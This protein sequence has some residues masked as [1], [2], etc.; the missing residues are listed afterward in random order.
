MYITYKVN[1]A[2]P[3]HLD[4][5][6]PCQ[7]SFSVKIVKDKF[8]IAAVADGLG[9]ELY[10]D[11]GSSVAVDMAVNY[12]AEHISE[13]LSLEKIE[14]ILRNSFLYAYKAVLARAEKD[15][16]SPDEYDTT[17]CLTVYDGEYLYYGQSGDSGLVVLLENGEYRYLTKQQRD[18]DGCVFPLCWG[19]DKWE[20]GSIDEAV[21]AFMLMTD[22][23]LDQICPPIMRMQNIDINIP[24]ARKFLDRFECNEDDVMMLE[25]AAYKYLE[26]FPRE[27]L[28]DDKTIVVIMN[29]ERKPGVKSDEYYAIPDRKVLRDETER[30][31][32]NDKNKR[33]FRQETNEVVEPNEK[34]DVKKNIVL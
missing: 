16:N 14:K 30:R 17:L 15:G 10:S 23:I 26:N 24:L 4:N 7:D 29:T 5:K 31:L 13:G 27:V 22:G 20:F 34:A 28:D 18:E 6:L 1:M 21:S 2:G 11:I 8:M 32:Y 25:E 3:Y 9:S 19:P 12:C 33:I